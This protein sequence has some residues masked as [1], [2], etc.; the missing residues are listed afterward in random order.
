MFVNPAVLK[1]T[2]RELNL[3]VMEGF[4]RM[5]RRSSR[6]TPSSQVCLRGRN[7]FTFNASHSPLPNPGEMVT[8]LRS[9]LT[10]EEHYTSHLARYE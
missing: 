6:G 2:S 5:N 9:R 4:V 7:I 10:K 8:L 1:N 3:P